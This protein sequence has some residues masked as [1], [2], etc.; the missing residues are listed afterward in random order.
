MATLIE[1]AKDLANSFILA[2][3][4]KDAASHIIFE[5]NRLVYS[6]SRQTFEFPVKM[7]IVKLI[8]EYISVKSKDSLVFLGTRDYI[9][10]QLN[11]N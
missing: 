7:E 9:L 3:N 10:K 11:A 1:I 5:I 4:K 6:D 2:R 8:Q